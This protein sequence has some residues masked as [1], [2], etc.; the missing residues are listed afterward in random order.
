MLSWRLAW[1]IL[2]A[3]ITARSARHGRTQTLDSHCRV[4]RDTPCRLM[5]LA[6]K[7]L[8]MGTAY[9]AW[10]GTRIGGRGIGGRVAVICRVLTD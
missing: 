7:R 1:L 4:L 2:A 5:A 8:E 10:A 9:A 3:S 6:T